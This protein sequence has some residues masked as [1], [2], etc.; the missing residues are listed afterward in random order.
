M[1][2]Y[3]SA[4]ALALCAAVAGCTS[5][6]HTSTTTTPS[7]TGIGA[8]MGTWTSAT[9]SGVIPPPSTCTDFKWNATEQTATTASGSFSATCAGDLKV[10][11]TASGT[12]T[13][14]TVAWSAN[15]TATVAGTAACPISLTGTAELGANSI[16][17]P[18]S[19]T[20]CAGPVSGVEI[21]N[22]K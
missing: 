21:L 16:R 7:S 12:L 20:T 1:K 6:E 19:G 14:T 18:Y 15:G 13:G 3:I 8:L 22:K 5:F 9:A 17:V 2:K 10:A 4:C 11:G